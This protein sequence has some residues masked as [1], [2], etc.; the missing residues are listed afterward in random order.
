MKD[1]KNN[2][3]HVGDSVALVVEHGK[4]VRLCTGIVKQTNIGPM[5]NLCEIEYEEYAYGDPN[6]SH[7]TYHDTVNIRMTDA[8]VLKLTT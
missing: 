3:L 8:K 1:I 7:R 4:K 6:I 5:N 2:E